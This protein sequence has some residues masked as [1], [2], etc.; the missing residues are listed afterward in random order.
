MPA[1]KQNLSDQTQTSLTINLE[2]LLGSNIPNSSLFRQGVGQDIIDAIRERTEKGRFLKVS[3]KWSQYS[4]GYKDSIAFKAYGK[5]NKVNL[6][7]SGE[8]L[9]GLDII[10]ETKNTI[11]IG[12]NDPLDAEKA[13][14]HITGNVGKKRD[15]LG[16]TEEE[17]KSIRSKW[18]DVLDDF[19]SA[20]EDT[21]SVTSSVAGTQEFV[22]GERSV[23]RF[24]S[25]NDIFQSLFGD[26]EV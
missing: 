16:L 17:I 19:K 24:T 11:K 21:G 12:W 23:K 4:E 9:D 6:R 3:G 26:G 15:F 25:L 13:H 5:T 2:E 14:G 22:T 1:Q 20:P 8:M 18:A 10:N 7:Q